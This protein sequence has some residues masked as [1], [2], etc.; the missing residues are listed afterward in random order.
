MDVRKDNVD[1][2][3]ISGHKIYGPKG[4]GAIFINKK[5]RVRLVPLLSG[6]G[7]EA[8]IRSGTLPVFLC[9]G[10]GEAANIINHE[11]DKD[12]AHYKAL[13]AIALDAVK[14]VPKV[15]VNG[16]REHRIP[17]NLNLSFLGVEGE[18]L[19]LAIDGK[20]AVSTGSA[21]TSQSLEPSHVLHAMG[22][23]AENAHTAVRIGFGRFTTEDEVKRGMDEIKKE[24]ARLRGISVLWDE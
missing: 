8:N 17:N 10:L 22:I 7:Q 1:L 6:G 2:M 16:S 24:V 19:M 3:S 23:P 4:V 21:C 20:V 5:N 14:D 18:S 13:S 12:I 15:V 11:M 9:V